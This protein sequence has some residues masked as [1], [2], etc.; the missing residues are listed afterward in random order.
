MRR[1]YLLSA[2]VLTG[3]LT[4]N[5]AVA[6][7]EPDLKEPVSAQS[8]TPTTQSNPVEML[9]CY[10][11]S[12]PVEATRMQ[13]VAALPRTIPNRQKI[14]QIEY[15]KEPF[16]VFYE[17]DNRY[18]EFLFVE[19]EKQTILT[20]N[21]KAE[22]YRHDLATAQS[23]YKTKPRKKVPLKE[24]LKHERYLEKD[25]VA[26]QKL[27][28]EMAGKTEIDRVRSIYEY[29]IDNMEYSI[30]G[31]D[32]L[33]ALVALERKKGD[34]TEYSDLFVTL[35]RAK[36]IAAR[37]TTGYTARFDEVSPK[38]H[39]AEVYFQDYG[40]VPFDASWGDTEDAFTRKAAFE[41]LKPVYIYLANMRNDPVLHNHHFFAY[42]YRGEKAAMTDSVKFFFRPEP[43][44][45]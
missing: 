17:N 15:S 45:R 16:R 39:W 5:A 23:R 26:I 25:D 18:A 13:F 32:D 31:K 10:A 14:L 34:C 30:Q 44:S 12:S 11:F 35:C 40:W 2:V 38:H 43:E 29:V 3:L 27:A 6:R 20:I 22:L 28:K 36:G 21:I 7:H 41:R 33:G 42:T 4:A 37:V 24:F 19:P 9:L 1:P 8:A